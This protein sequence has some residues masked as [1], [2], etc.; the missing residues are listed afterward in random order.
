[1]RASSGVQPAY[2][3]ENHDLDVTNQEVEDRDDSISP[4]G[5]PRGPSPEPK[6]EDSECHRSQ[7]A[8]FL[9]HWNRGDFNSCARTDLTFKPVPESKLARKREE[10]LRKQAEKEREERERANQSRKQGT[11]PDAKRE[12]PK[13]QSSSVGLVPGVMLDS[14]M[15]NTPY[16]RFTPRSGFPD[17]PALRQL[18]EYARPHTGFSPGSQLRPGTGGM[19]PGHPLEH[20]LGSSYQIGLYGPGTRER[21]EMEAFEKRERE[22]REIRERELSDRLKEEFLRSVPSNARHQADTSGGP[23]NGGPRLTNPLDAHWL[24]AHRRFGPL[25]PSGPGMGGLHPPFAMYQTGGPSALSPLERERLERLG[26]PTS[27]GLQMQNDSLTERLH[28]ERL[29]MD[30]RLQLGPMQGYGGM[31][32]MLHPG[33]GVYQRGHGLIPTRDAM[34]LHPDL[35]GRPYPPE[36]AHHI[37]AHEQLQRHILLDRERQYQG[38]P[39]APPP[40]LQHHPTFLAQQEEYLRQQQQRD[41]ELKVRALEEAARRH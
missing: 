7:S 1:V 8:I 33:S 23:N 38:H 22:I 2:N 15:N 40:G 19:V 25:G 41:R 11:T 3:Q 4:H 30:M 14:Q 29:A 24:D 28:A 21:L 32:P 13:P 10:R 27:M 39:S 16:D 36:L 12:T 34:A 35:L 37:N 18:S 9:R 6:V 5:V 31:D 20:V 26:I 17:T